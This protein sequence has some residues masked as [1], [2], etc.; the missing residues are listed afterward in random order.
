MED[1]D[2]PM[3]L[4]VAGHDAPQNTLH[5]SSR[6]PLGARLDSVFP[7]AVPGGGHSPLRQLSLVRREEYRL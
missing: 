2:P 1:P 5:L 3:D 7:V 6:V 4:G